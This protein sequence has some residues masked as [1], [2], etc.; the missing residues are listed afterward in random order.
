MTKKKVHE[1]GYEHELRITQ[2]KPGEA[3]VYLKR[4]ILGK[5]P[6]EYSFHLKS[7]A[8]LR[9]LMDL[10]DAFA[11][12][13]EETFR[14]HVSEYKNDF[15]QWIEDIFNDY[16]LARQIRA[17]RTPIEAQNVVLKRML[18]ELKQLLPEKIT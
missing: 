16:D 14:Y 18:R 7:G 10:A 15:A 11:S 8:K 9:D 5:A 6:E 12:M 1:E 13:G 3:D 4:K 17:V 2:T